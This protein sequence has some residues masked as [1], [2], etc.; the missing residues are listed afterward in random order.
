MAVLAG[1]R[2]LREHRAYV[3]VFAVAVV[4]EVNVGNTPFV[5]VL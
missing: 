3:I 2:A 5:Q 4:K 1:I